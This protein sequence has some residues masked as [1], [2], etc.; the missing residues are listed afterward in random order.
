MNCSEISVSGTEIQADHPSF[1]YYKFRIIFGVIW[2]EIWMSQICF[3]KSP[4]GKSD[5]NVFRSEPEPPTKRKRDKLQPAS[6]PFSAYPVEESQ[7]LI[8][9][10]HDGTAQHRGQWRVVS[11]DRLS[12]GF[13]QMGE[14][15]PSC[16]FPGFLFLTTLLCFFCF[17]CI[18]TIKFF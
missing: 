18:T 14:M 4:G 1:F 11:F 13:L 17:R 3:D 7:C 2:H 10:F 15:V 5:W 9:I 6:F 8:L 16:S 12:S